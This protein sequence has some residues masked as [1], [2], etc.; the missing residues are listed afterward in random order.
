MADHLVVYNGEAPPLD[1]SVASALAVLARG[2]EYRLTTSIGLFLA[3]LSPWQPAVVATAP[4][5]TLVAKPT[6]TTR[7][8]VEALRITISSR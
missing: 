7:H 5:P 4:S 3:S 6:D 2:E 8:H 1:G